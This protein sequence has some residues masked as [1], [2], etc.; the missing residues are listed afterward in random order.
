MCGIAGVMSFAENGFRV[1]PAWLNRMRDSMVHRGPDGAGCW[2]SPNARVGLAHRR[3]AIIDRSEAASQPM[4][5]HDGSLCLS[6]NGEIYNHAEIRSELKSLGYRR[7]KTSHSDTEVLLHA[8][9]HWGIEC[10]ERLRGMFA[11]AV[12]DERQQELWL[13]RDRIGVKPLYY[14]MHHGR[15]CFASEIKALLA[16]PQVPRQI[17]HEGFFHYLTFLTTPAP[18]T[19]FE[20]IHKLAPATWMKIDRHG[21]QTVR[22]YW[23]VWENTEPLVGLDEED[24]A[25]RLLSELRTSVELRKVGDVPVGVFLSGGIDSSANAALFSDHQSD[26]PS[27]VKT[28]T[29]GYDD[30]STDYRNEV[31]FARRMAREVNSEHHELMISQQELL[32]FLPQMIH[33]QD[34]P[35]GDPVCVPL[36]YVSKLARDNGVVVCQVGEG[37]DEL[38]WGY[39][40]WRRS[41]R[42]QQVLDRS[43]FPRGLRRACTAHWKRCGGLTGHRWEMFD[44]DANGLPIFWGS[45][46]AFPH[47]QK[48]RLLSPEL[49]RKFAGLSSWEP[50]RELRQRFEATAWDP[51]PLHWMS[52]VDLNLRLPE[53]LLMRVD[54]MT[55]GVSLEG[56][57]P[58]LDHKFVELAMSIPPAVK[59]RNGTLKHI[60]K[61]SVRG[62]IPD[63]LIDRRKQGFGVPVH[64]WLLGDLGDLARQKIDRFTRETGLLDSTATQDIQSHA[65]CQRTWFL[66]NVALW[67]EHF[68]TDT[69]SADDSL[70]RAG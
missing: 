58:F 61:K 6:F 21:R 35:I 49:R 66:L 68:F 4:A 50:L 10:L 36:Y 29:I 26:D 51:G 57:V 60:L 31:D 55:M 16:D 18:Q 47:T 8:F 25:E 46:N 45:I 24:I 7:W 62:V 52:Y 14:C 67:W 70:Q 48:M 56:R 69:N 27:P 1:A 28:F 39:E 20:G 53:L 43:P 9:E 37:S 41:M 44:R 3:L 11:F 22:R 2:I 64:D 19:L 30:P 63:A 65:N 15:I 33:L 54:K 42:L 17:N 12:W 23:D 34:E 32:D 38:F 40:S 13:V 5:N 59:T